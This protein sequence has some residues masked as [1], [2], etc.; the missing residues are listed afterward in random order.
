MDNYTISGK[1][2]LNLLRT[3][4]EK[5]Y[6]RFIIE[7]ENI[8][9]NIARKFEND[10]TKFHASCGCTTGNYFLITTLIL[11]AAYLYLT[12]QTVNNW[13]MIIQGFFILLSAAILGKFIGKLM[14][15][16][17]FKKTVEKLGRQLL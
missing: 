16:F 6:A 14:Y 3:K 1:E 11:G 8:D 4:K 5:R 17:K 2:S 10:L 15:G 9:E 13:K 7:V 12:G